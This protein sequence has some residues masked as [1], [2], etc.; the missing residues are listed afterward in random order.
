MIHQDRCL[1]PTPPTD[2][3]DEHRGR[4]LMQQY[5][6][7]LMH[8]FESVLISIY[9]AF[10]GRLVMF[11]CTNDHDIEFLPFHTG[12]KVASSHAAIDGPKKFRKRVCNSQGTTLPTPRLQSRIEIHARGQTPQKLPLDSQHSQTEVGCERVIRQD[13][14]TLQ[15]RIRGPPVLVE[16]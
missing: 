3:Q 13:A 7:S 1:A 2:I 8:S 12:Q 15:F 14:Q 11:T 10:S 16:T 4:T 5:H 6:R 9:K